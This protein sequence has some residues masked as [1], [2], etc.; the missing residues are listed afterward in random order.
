MNLTPSPVVG[1]AFKAGRSG[2]WFN[3]ILKLGY[4]ENIWSEA[5]VLFANYNI[6]LSAWLAKIQ[7]KLH[8][9]MILRFC[10]YS[11]HNDNFQF[12]GACSH[13][14]IITSWY[15]SWYRWKEENINIGTLQ[16]IWSY[17]TFAID[18]PGGWVTWHLLLINQGGCSNPSSA[19][20]FLNKRL[21]RTQV[22][23]WFIKTNILD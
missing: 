9:F 2:G 4:F 11:T 16:Q 12:S 3:S 20:M 18:N 15:L 17:V 10:L 6:H 8:I 19:N 14:D 13:Y 22:M 1:W 5:Q 23:H 7:K 21:Q